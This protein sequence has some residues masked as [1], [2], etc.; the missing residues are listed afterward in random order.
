MTTAPVRPDA[1]PLDL[2]ALRRLVGNPQLTAAEAAQV[3]DILTVTEA[4]TQVEELIAER[5]ARVLRM[6]AAARRIRPV[7]RQTLQ[8]PADTATRRTS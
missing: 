4:R 7:A 6:L 2:Q 5:R 8:Q 1:K 3:R